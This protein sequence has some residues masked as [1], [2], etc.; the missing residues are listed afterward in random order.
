MN[1]IQPRLIARSNVAA[2]VMAIIA[3]KIPFKAD[4]L[5]LTDNLREIGVESV[6][7]LEMVF[8]LE[9]KFGIEIPYNANTS[10]QEFVTVADV[11]A[12]VEGLLVKKA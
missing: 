1:E 7:A 5:R 9:E 4:G 12:A 10:E 2:D 6:D 8:D 11:I 3:A